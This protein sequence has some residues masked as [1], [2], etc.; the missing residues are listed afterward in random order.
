MQVL[1]RK[2]EAATISVLYKKVFLKI[3]Q[4]SQA[5]NF[6]KKET[7]TQGFP[8]NFAKFL[9]TPFSQ[10]TSRLLL[11]EN[12]SFEFRKIAEKLFNT[13]YSTNSVL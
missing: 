5:C 2:S 8:V 6:V 7:L 1:L 4:N 11:V 10:N 9:R 12:P 3:S 13:M